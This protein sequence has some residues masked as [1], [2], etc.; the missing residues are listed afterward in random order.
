MK[1]IFLAF[2]LLMADACWSQCR[3]A[4]WWLGFD[5]KGWVTCG[6]I[7]EYLTGLYRNINKGSNDG[8][9]LIEESRCCKAP[10]PN[11]NQ[12]ST[13]VTANWWG[14]LD[15]NKRWAV[16]PEGYFMQGMYRNDGQ[17]LHHIE[18]SRCCKPKNLP[19]SY[20]HCYNADSVGLSFDK[21]GWSSCAAGYYMAGF[22]K[23]GC[24]RLYCIESFKC[25]SM[26][27]ECKMA[28]WWAGFDRKG[29]VHC[30]SSKHYITGL[31]RNTNLGSKDEIYLLEQAKCCPAPSPHQNTPSTCRTANWW[32][33]LD[34]TNVW[35]VCPPGYFLRGLFRNTGTWLHHIEEATC[36][37]PQTLADKYQDCYFENIWYSFD[38]KGIVKCNRND[39]Y[40]AGIYKGGCDQLHCIELLFCCKMMT[41]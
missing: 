20:L 17:W 18:E 16:C 35:A 32:I 29:W 36:C 27:N 10:S 30:D 6:Y 24:D 41:G 3:T 11:E 4:N 12:P 39:Y 38:R 40:L 37:K 5:K 15:S 22:Y 13:C 7:N 34:R 8:I 9:Y 14:I 28:N 2:V 26:Q 23:G 21:K 31:W 25:C 19:N 33:T 1:I